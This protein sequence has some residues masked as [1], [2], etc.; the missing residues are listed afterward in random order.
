MQL[1]IAREDGKGSN[2]GKQTTHRFCPI[3]WWNHQSNPRNLQTC[4]ITHVRLFRLDVASLPKRKATKQA[5]QAH[6]KSPQ[7]VCQPVPLSGKSY[8]LS[9]E[10]SPARAF[11]GCL[12]R[13]P[14]SS[15]VSVY[16]KPTPRHRRAQATTAGLSTP[17]RPWGGD[18]RPS[19]RSGQGLSRRSESGMYLDWVEEP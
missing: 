6:L 4:F 3:T 2:Q 13:V 8:P 5:K 12:G 1:G 11:N 16:H 9:L 7:E 18:Q 14:K 19:L 17:R 10:S 15:P